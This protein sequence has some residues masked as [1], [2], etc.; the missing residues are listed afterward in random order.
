[1]KN[2]SL[3]AVVKLLVLVA[4]GI[5]HVSAQVSFQTQYRIDIQNVGTQPLYWQ[6]TD[7][8]GE[9]GGCASMPGAGST[10]QVLNPQTTNG[11]V[12]TVYVSWGS[13]DCT[14]FTVP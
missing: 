11:T 3:R 6:I 1:M 2:R 12:I 14:T 10:E 4:L 5:C 7:N 13:N 8:I 9:T